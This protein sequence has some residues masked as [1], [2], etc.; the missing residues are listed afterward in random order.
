MGD[1]WMMVMSSGH[2]DGHQQWP[3]TAAVSEGQRELSGAMTVGE[4]SL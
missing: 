2:G 4:V 3:C 1:S